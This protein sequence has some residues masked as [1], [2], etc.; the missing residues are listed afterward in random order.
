MGLGSLLPGRGGD[1]GV[2]G[3]GAPGGHGLVGSQTWARVSQTLQSSFYQPFGCL[4]VI[5]DVFMVFMV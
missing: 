1:G 3:S 2:A 4:E 5:G